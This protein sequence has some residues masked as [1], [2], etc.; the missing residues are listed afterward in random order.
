MTERLPLP[1]GSR[2]D[3]TRKIGFRFDGRPLEGF[4]GD[5]IASAMAGA[6]RWIL[7]RSFKYHRP[8]GVMTMAGQDANTLV[9]LPDEPNV[10]A[11]LRPISEGLEVTAQ[12]VIG[13]AEHD[14]GAILDR[15]GR[16]MPVGFYYRAFFRPG[17]QS[18]LKFWEPII[19]KSAGLGKVDLGAGHGAYIKENL[20]TDVLVVGAGPAGLSAAIAAAGA[21]AQVLLVDL[22]PE[23]GGALTY[24]R[25]GLDSETADSALKSLREMAQALLNLRIMTEATCNGW[26]ADNWLPVLQGNRL[27]RVR[28]KQVVVAAGAQEQ[29]LVF[30]NNDLPGVLLSSAAQRLMRHYAVRP[31][32][33]AVV[34]AGN[35][36]GYLAALDLAEAG[37]PV[38]AVLDPAQGPAFPDLVRRLEQHKIRLVSNATITEALG[39]RHIHAVGFTTKS[40]RE[41]IDCD[42]LVVAAGYTPGYQLPLHAGAKLGYDDASRQFVLND[43][44]EGL[45]VAGSA[46]GYFELASVLLSGEA[47]G[48]AAARTA[49]HDAS[50]PALIADALAPGMNYAP[51]LTPHPKGRDFIDFDEDL[52]VKDIKNAVGDGY[53]ELELV[54]RYS[55]VGMGPSQGRHSALATARIVAAETGRKVAQV[56]ITTA[57]PP[58]GPEKL[59]LLAGPGHV[60]Y[61]HTPMHADHLAR[62]AKMTPAGVWWRPLHYGAGRTDIAQVIAQEVALVRGKAA[63]LDV[64]TLGK[65]AI[66]GPD[67]AAFIDRIYTMAHLK[68]PVGRVR[69]C[70]MLND[71]GSVI[72]DGVAYRLSETEFYVTATTGAVARVFA[73]MLFLNAQ[74]GMQVDIQNVTAAFAAI[75]VT[76]PEARRALEALGGDIDLAPEN[77]PYLAGRTGTVGG[78]PVRIMRIGFTGE[79]SYELHVPQYYGAGL[80]RRLIEAGV[81]PYGLEASRILRLEKG[82]IIIGQDTDALSTPDEL[83][84]GWALSKTKA[85][86]IGKTAVE[87]RRK[88]P[89]KRR[90]C[91]FALPEGHDTRLAESCLVFRDGRP[92]GFV[93]STCFSPT[94]G[95][96]IGLAYADPRDAD[97]GG[98]ITIRGLCGTEIAA[99]VIPTPFYDPENL[100]QEM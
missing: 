23:T 47:A 60:L 73:E 8:R 32:R 1:W 44:P 2:L 59:G 85:R 12:N 94:L 67:A 9:Q 91:G 68:Q 97:S 4:A 57:R 66:R 100:R 72:D 82:H 77:F 18:W 53:R 5:T 80:W 28:A 19:R 11:D 88:L 83:N 13:T 89:L 45:H 55:T 50:P 15:F 14:R 20:H 62:G 63:M 31:G 7:S 61:R 98:R 65:L 81:R 48:A 35:R 26:F 39:T 37:V 25:F 52:Q 87:A 96:W 3:R 24:A 27:Y 95:K 21:G 69:Y 70:L 6:D 38:A 84:M 40:G 17:A 71:M 49:G 78:C 29:P 46:A 86:H 36:D 58:F 42:L 76:G 92:V 41:Q 22:A 30:R 10:R 64:S 56:G 99:K 79:L 75:N 51:R 93:T 54:K 34:F 43:L 90:L 74:W 33:R 16:F